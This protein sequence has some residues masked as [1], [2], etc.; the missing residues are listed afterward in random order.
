MP[1]RRSRRV[2][3]SIAP[4]PLTGACPL[5]LVDLVRGII[6]AA[7]DLSRASRAR[8]VVRGCADFDVVPT[9]PFRNSFR[10]QTNKGHGEQVFLAVPETI[11][12]VSHAAKAP[13][14]GSQSGSRMVHEQRNA[15]AT[16]KAWGAL[17]AADGNLHKA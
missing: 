16:A 13:A 1:A 11:N 14:S 4:S 7:R 6:Y 5:A 12:L 3:L 2:P 8:W 17:G 9:E 15:A 10:V